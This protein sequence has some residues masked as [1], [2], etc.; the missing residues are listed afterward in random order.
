MPFVFSFM[1]AGNSYRLSGEGT[2][3]KD[4]TAAAFAELKLLNKQDIASL[5]TQTKLQKK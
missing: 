2:G 4:A 5:V 3:A 1:A